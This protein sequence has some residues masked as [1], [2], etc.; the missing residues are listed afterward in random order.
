[1]IIDKDLIL[2]DA[3]AV[4]AS[5]A[6]DNY[7][8]QGAAGDAVRP[9]IL[10]VMCNTTADSTNDTATV[11]VSIQTDDNSSFSTPATLATSA[12]FAIGDAGVTAGGSVME[13]ALPAGLQRY[14]RVYYTIGTQN[15]T[16]GKFDAFIVRDVKL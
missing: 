3:Q 1:M 16:A 8:D 7:I 12:S 10:K 11:V 2:S 13:V 5:A 4:T 6:S 15:L 9:C 14:I